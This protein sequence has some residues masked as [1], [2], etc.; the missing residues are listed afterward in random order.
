MQHGCVSF[1]HALGLALTLACA[2]SGLR[3]VE[4]VPPEADWKFLRGLSEASSPDP[5]AWRQPGFDDRAWET[6]PAPFWYG[7]AQPAPGTQLTD[8]RG[9]YTCVFLR[10]H[11]VVA[12]PEDLSAVTLTALSDD[13]FIAWINGVEIARFNMPDRE[14]AY[15]ESSLPA[16][17]E[18]IDPV[19]YTDTDPRRFLQVGTNVLAVQAFNSSLANSSD[20]VFNAS[21]AGTADETPPVVIALLP[22]AGATV[23]EL[24]TVEV[25]FS[26]AVTGVDAGDLLINGAA[27]TQLTAVSPSQFVFQFPPPPTGRVDVA[28]AG[29]HGI[30]DLAGTPHPFAGGSWSYTLNPNAPPPGVMISEFM[31]ENDDTLNDEDGDAS[32]WI[33]LH[34]PTTSVVSLNGWFLTDNPDTPAKWRFPNVA[35]PARGYLL[36]FASGKNRTNP[37][38]RLHT[39]FKLSRNGGFLALLDPATNIVSAFAPAYPPQQAD[40]SYGRATGAPEVTGYFLKPTPGTE[41]KDSGPGFAPEVTFSRRGGTF[42]EPFTLVLSTPD[43]AATIYYTLNGTLPTNTSTV[44]TGPL[45]VSTSVLV[46]ARALVT[47]LLPGPIRSEGYVALGPTVLNRTSDLPQM[48]LHNFGGGTFVASADKPAYLTVCEPVN[49]VSSLTNRADFRGRAGV[50]LRGS[51]TEGYPKRSFAVEFWNEVNADRDREIL[52]MPAESDWVLYAPNNFEPVLIHNPYIFELSRRIGRYAPRT[53]FVE[54]YVNT[55]AGPLST[56]HYQGI[57]VLMEKIKRGPD[58]VAVDNLEPE[59]T[60]PPAVTGGYVL[61]ID[62]QDWNERSFYT[63]G[64][65]VI[66]VDPKG[67][68]MDL[69]QRAPQAQY[70]RNYFDALDAALSSPEPGDPVT[71]YPAYVDIPSWLDHHILNILAF[72]VDALRLSGYFY[73]PRNGRIEMGP[74]WDFDRALGSTDGRDSAPRVWRSAVPDYGTDMFNSDWIFPNPWYSRMFRD[75]DFWQA[76]IDRWQ[77]LRRGEFA[78]TNLHNLVESLAAEVW[79]AQPREVAKWPGHAP[80]GGS[81]RAEVNLMKTWLSNRV[82]FLDTNFLGAPVLGRA[83]GG[84]VPGTEVSLTG[85]AG[86]TVYFTTDGSDPRLP[87]GAVSPRAATSTGAVRIHANTRIVARAYNPAHRNLTGPNKPPLSSPWSGPVAATYVTATPRLVITEIMY[88]PA[89]PGDG[90]LE[91]GEFE[92]V[93]LRNVGTQPLSLPGFRFSR[94]IEFTF[95]ATNAVTSLAPGAHVLVVKNRAA[96]AAR[97]PGVGNIAGEYQGA[98]DNAGERLVLEGPL[99][100]PILDFRYEDAWWPITDGPGFSLVIRDDSAPL[101][102]WAAGAHWRP[103]ARPGGSPGQADPA[104]PDLPVVWINEALT[105]T[106]PP[107]VDSIEL[108][109]PGPAAADL[110]GWFLTDDFSQP[111]KFVIPA[112][113]TAPAGGFLEFTEADFNTG[114]GR[115]TLSSLG[116]AVYLFSGD[117]TNLTGYMHGFE[118]G[119]AAHGVS[120]GRHV[121]STG[122]ERFVAQVSRTPRAANAGPRIG[123]VVLSE[124]MFQPPPAG[125]NNNTLDEFLELQNVSAGSVPLY[126]P[127]AATNTWRLRG[128]VEFDFPPGVVLSAGQTLLLVNFDPEFD[129]GPLA[130]FRAR[131]HVPADTRILGPYR[132]NLNNAGERLALY[133]PDPPQ[134]PD[135]PNPGEAPRVLVEEVHYSPLP[136]W[137]AGANGTG[138]SL[139]RVNVRL[140]G[141]DPANWQA[142]EPTAGRPAPDS[143]PDWDDDGLPNDWEIAMGLDPHNATGDHGAHGD[144]DRDGLINLAEFQAGTHPGE[145]ASVLEIRGVDVSAVE[146]VIRFEAVDGR[147]YSVLFADDPANGPWQRLA[148]VP[149]EPGV[150]EVVVRDPAHAATRYYRL[151]TPKLP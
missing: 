63:A 118:F 94:G 32:D 122:A 61:K 98:L 108:H 25:E 16:L 131:Y 147:T 133:R 38:V 70:I 109:N 105:H 111:R 138:L 8:M 81:Y 57:Y 139:Q 33:E 141:D 95:T 103:S 22:P 129:F 120:F 56:A 59:H 27:A 142:A 137:P 115:F 90:A 93:E 5:A 68:E 126:D 100:E 58:R 101:D 55:T 76:W 40:I 116:E 113:T 66:Y 75:I 52:G 41:N 92:F 23:R 10:R 62:R 11:F 45:T 91:D 144:P 97:Y 18:P 30:R 2:G 64:V 6:R 151:V 9:G 53:R 107:L 24:T 44:Y 60:Q 148:D 51:S 47:G 117:G 15:Y 29:G 110:G 12:H 28:W 87:G 114:P 73:K 80:R 123:P 99:R 20:F 74:I 96:F 71:G 85:P 3:A 42:V 86:A 121:T 130:A 49:G 83:G 7:D 34:N 82:D 88:H 102:H 48:I 4:L 84:V 26:E 146:T 72:N 149:A 145:A 77:E 36:L 46:R 1:R 50:N 143:D 14:L 79:K 127:E 119:A 104:P 21:L 35:L 39:N 112:G 125:T 136:P 43:P 13:G 150:R 17:P 135:S 69:P 54:L 128:G 65:G 106:D 31:A 134:T 37:Q 140:F 132:G 124:I 78:L 19:T 67:P 89:A